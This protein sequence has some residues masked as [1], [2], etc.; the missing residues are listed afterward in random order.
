[1]LSGTK[2]KLQ[3]LSGTSINACVG[4]GGG[5]PVPPTKAWA[6]PSKSSTCALLVELPNAPGT[7]WIVGWDAWTVWLLSCPN[8][9]RQLC[10]VF[11]RKPGLN[12]VT[13][14][15][16]DMQVLTLRSVFDVDTPQLRDC[17]HAQNASVKSRHASTAWL[18]SCPQMQVF[19]LR[20]VLDVDTPQLRDFCHAQHASVK[21]TKHFWSRH[22]SIAWLLSSPR[23]K[24]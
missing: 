3:M 18:L 23:C 9:S 4:G 7:R 21:S 19:S 12:S 17:C 14:V 13:V 2:H 20:C 16:L 11:L 5:T 8:C 15:I 10:E 24:C 1:M 22:A 6:E